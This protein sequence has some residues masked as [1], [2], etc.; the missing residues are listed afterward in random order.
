MQSGNWRENLTLD[1]TS[2]VNDHPRLV[3]RVWTS[4]K[5]LFTLIM[6]AVDR[7]ALLAVEWF[8][9]RKLRNQNSFRIFQKFLG[10]EYDLDQN[11]LT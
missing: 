7:W 11:V 4:Q 5:K 3:P 10:N 8:A 9:F 1:A 6:P 2:D